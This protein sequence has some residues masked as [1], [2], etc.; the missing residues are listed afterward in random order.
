MAKQKRE[1]NTFKFVLGKRIARYRKENTDYSQAD[2]AFAVGVTPNTIHNYETG[3]IQPPVDILYRIA[4]ELYV[5]ID[6]LTG[7]SS[8]EGADVVRS[9]F[10]Y[11]EIYTKESTKNGDYDLCEIVPKE[12]QRTGDKKG[13]YAY[14]FE[15][16]M[17]GVDSTELF[18]VVLSRYNE[19]LKAPAGS[20]V[21]IQRV[22]DPDF[23]K[24]QE[25]A[26]VLMNANVDFDG[27]KSKTVSFFTKLSP[28][29]NTGSTIF[30]ENIELSHRWMFNFPL[31]GKEK[32]IYEK[33]LGNLISGIVKKVIID[34]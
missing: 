15:A 16:N 1:N 17:A 2:L 5:S 19:C 26:V 9:L 13:S 12:Y 27:N 23:I 14:N 24:L 10:V 3:K 4:K 6:V 31:N 33:Y 28:V 34:Y 8:I 7:T 21:I 22:R 18:A 20:V 32:I 29:S 30:Y 11:D 25:P